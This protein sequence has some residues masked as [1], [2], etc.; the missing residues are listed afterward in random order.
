MRRAL[1]LACSQRKVPTPDLLPAIDRY[2]GPAFRVVRRYL[3]T[4][5][6]SDLIVYIVSAEFG[7]IPSCRPIPLYDRR[8]TDD[9]ATELAPSIVR[10]LTAVSQATQPSHLYRYSALSRAS[11]RHS[12]GKGL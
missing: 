12:G 8:M 7:L 9:R 11:S 4:N 1:L 2:D 6:D 3:R 10:A 5:S